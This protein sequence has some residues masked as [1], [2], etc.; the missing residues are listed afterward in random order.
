MHKTEWQ[1]LVDR[2]DTIERALEMV[3]RTLG[4]VSTMVARWICP[5]CGE[6]MRD[7]E[8]DERAEQGWRRCPACQHLEGIRGEYHRQVRTRPATRQGAAAYRQSPTRRA[9]TLARAR[10]DEGEE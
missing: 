6:E 8:V 10:K 4:H 9:S 3:Q 1:S 5:V 7:H 2:V